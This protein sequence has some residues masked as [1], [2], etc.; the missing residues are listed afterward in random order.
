MVNETS[1][2][3][4]SRSVLL[5]LGLD[6]RVSGIGVCRGEKG[7]GP[8]GPLGWGT[9]APESLRSFTLP[10][11]RHRN[12]CWG[13]T[14]GH[15]KGQRKV[16]DSSYGSVRFDALWWRCLLLCRRPAVCL[17]ARAICARQRAAAPRGFSILFFLA[18]GELSRGWGA[19]P[20]ELL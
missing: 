1:C 11:H 17:F 16:I 8:R 19:C 2:V 6:S 13:A 9:A 7:G 3:L 10:S 14:Q 18:Q 20:C 5:F 12:C 15:E 4:H